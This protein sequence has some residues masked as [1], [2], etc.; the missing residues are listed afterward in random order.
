M[1]K[2]DSYPRLV[3]ALCGTFSTRYCLTN[4][5][6]VI[7][8]GL[9]AAISSTSRYGFA[10]AHAFAALRARQ[11]VCRH[12]SSFRPLK[13]GAVIDFQVL[14]GL[15]RR[16]PLRFHLSSSPKGDSIDTRFEL[17][18]KVSKSFAFNACQI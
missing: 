6:T 10:A 4:S 1:R 2:N 17:H 14:G 11:Q 13:N 16:K 18:K 5:P 15:F 9:E 12:A 8:D 3:L 7:A